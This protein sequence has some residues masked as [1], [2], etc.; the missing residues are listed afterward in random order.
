MYFIIVKDIEDWLDIN[1]CIW[2]RVI[3]MHLQCIS[4]YFSLLLSSLVG[5]SILALGSIILNVVLLSQKLAQPQ[6]SASK[7]LPAKT[8]PKPRNCLKPTAVVSSNSPDRIN[9]HVCHNDADIESSYDSEPT[10]FLSKL[11]FGKKRK[12]QRKEMWKNWHNKFRRKKN[13][14]C[15]LGQTD[16][17]PIDACNDSST[18]TSQPLSPITCDT[19]PPGSDSDIP[20]TLDST[21]KQRKGSGHTEELLDEISLELSSPERVVR[22]NHTGDSLL[23][24]SPATTL[25]QSQARPNHVFHPTDETVL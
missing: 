7:S 12:Q 25:S 8:K 13:G 9:N 22:S 10:S 4:L 2:N 17:L 15:E 20:N 14:Y 23:A 5:L 1:T 21:E 18:F 19:P 3:C 24:A 11:S 16:D 6:S